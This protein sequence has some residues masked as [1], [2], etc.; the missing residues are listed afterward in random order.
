[1]QWDPLSLHRKIRRV[2]TDT[3]PST[4]VGQNMFVVP[5]YCK[6][7][8][9]DSSRS[10]VRFGGRAVRNLRSK[11]DVEKVRAGASNDVVASVE[12][13]AF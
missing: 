2:K 6:H 7:F 13:L 8:R 3:T 10:C 5:R 1:M 11:N 12:I 9:G 4:D